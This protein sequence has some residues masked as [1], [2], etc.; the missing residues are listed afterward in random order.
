[1]INPSFFFPGVKLNKRARKYKEMSIER[2]RKKLLYQM[3]KIAKKNG[4]LYLDEVNRF[5]KN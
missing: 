1:M 5:P 2:D 4:V 3:G